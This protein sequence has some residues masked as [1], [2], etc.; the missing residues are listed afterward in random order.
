M[1][2]TAGPLSAASAADPDFEVTARETQQA[3]L[4]AELFCLAL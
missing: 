1:V 4:S 3:I 2:T